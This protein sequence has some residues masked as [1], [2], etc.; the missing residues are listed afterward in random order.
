MREEGRRRWSSQTAELRG[1][2]VERKGE[3]DPRQGVNLFRLNFRGM[4]YRS[5]M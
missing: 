3:L 2:V 1:V 4:N 5:V